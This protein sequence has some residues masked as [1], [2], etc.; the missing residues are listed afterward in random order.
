M[1]NEI[2]DAR[3]LSR[4]EDPETSH[5]AGASVDASN[6]MLKIYSVMKKFG[7]DGCITDEVLEYFPEHGVQTISPRFR[8]MLDRGMIELTG[9]KR[10]GNCGRKQLV[11]RALPPPFHRPR[12]SSRVK[13]LEEENKRLRSEIEQLRARLPAREIE[14]EQ[15][16]LF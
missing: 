4:E 10:E 11:R 13:V 16:P 2:D 8:Q 3:G 6:L 14:D 1:S 5:L 15:I 9:A 7:A 12:R